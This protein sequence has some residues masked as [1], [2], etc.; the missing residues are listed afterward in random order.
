MASSSCLACSGCLS[1]PSFCLDDLQLLGVLLLAWTVV[2]GVGRS[3]IL[4]P[5]P[6]A[7]TGCSTYCRCVCSEDRPWYLLSLPSPWSGVVGGLQDIVKFLSSAA[8]P[9]RCPSGWRS[10]CCIDHLLLWLGGDLLLVAG[11]ACSHFMFRDVGGSRWYLGL[12]TW[13]PSLS[14]N[15]CTSWTCP[16]DPPSPCCRGWDGNSFFLCLLF[17]A[18]CRG[19]SFSFYFL[20]LQLFIF[21]SLKGW[22][23]PFSL[24]VFPTLSCLHHLA[25][26]V[27]PWHMYSWTSF[28]SS[29]FFSVRV[30][31]YVLLVY[32]SLLFAVW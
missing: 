32:F 12:A 20:H 13:L 8:S 19:G 24:W 16:R 22:P 4:C 26:G 10:C 6:C 11:Q 30:L 3:P 23:L 9:T 5:W 14:A 27:V 21:S 29:V 28:S 7:W 2:G 17:L 18:V 1:L 15:C 25:H 31:I